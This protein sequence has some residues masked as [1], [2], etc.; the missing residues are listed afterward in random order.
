M[1]LLFDPDPPYVRWYSGKSGLHAQKFTTALYRNE[2]QNL[3]SKN[4]KAIGYL[5][6]H[7]GEEITEPAKLIPQAS[8][9]QIE[10]SVRFLPAHNEMTLRLARYWVR[11]MPEI[12]H[13]LFC[14]TAL[15]ANL[16]SEASTYAIPYRLRNEGIRR[17]GGDGLCHQWTWQQA[18]ALKSKVY[19]RM[20]SVHLG[21]ATNVAASLNGKAVETSIGFTP[22]EG[23]ISSTGCGDI[24]TAIVLQLVSAGMS[25]EEVNQL[26]SRE[27]GFAGLL[28]KRH[29]LVNILH[30]NGDGSVNFT[31]ELFSYQLKKYI[32]AFVAV[33][34]GLDA[35]V[36]ACDDPGKSGLLIGEIC[37]SLGF[38]GLKTRENPNEQH[39]C[40]IFSEDDSGIDVLCFKYDQWNTLA[41][42]LTYVI[43]KEYQS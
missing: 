16:P 38:L 10:N 28:G 2:F 19:K 6:H 33:L 1:T 14:D 34:G 9:S 41:K 12:P 40:R 37:L 18:N 35:L 30:A 29:G 21:D 26:L 32:G 23:I 25:L 7:G 43:S 22:I 17:Y 20:I 42:N 39:G 4:P 13:V 31:R 27:G 3:K 15:F 24:D 8:L 5:L 11:E 36:F